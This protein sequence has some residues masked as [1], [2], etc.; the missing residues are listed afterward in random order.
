M[1]QVR[2][3]KGEPNRAGPRASGPAMNGFVQLAMIA[4]LLSARA[5]ACQTPTDG[6]GSGNQGATQRGAAQAAPAVQPPTA[7]DLHFMTGMISHH[8]QAVVMA[9][10]A[11][12]HGA[13]PSMLALCDRIA[14]SQTDEIKYI[15]TWLA[16][17]HQAVPQPDPHGLTMA[18]MDRPMLMPGMLSPEQ[19]AT[20]DQ[21]RGAAFDR[22]FLQDMIL[23]H[24]GAIAMTQDLMNSYGAA[25][26]PLLFQF[27]TDVTANQTAEIERMTRML[28]ALPPATPGQ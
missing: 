6:S 14:V 2:S 10:W 11:P 24:Q 28:A 26:D 19:M 17:R 25:Q 12:S 21:A 27:A 23:H 15:Q 8:A 18:G 7:A 5:I 4:G 22:L 3:R 13:S 20:L 1:F 9:G 16:D